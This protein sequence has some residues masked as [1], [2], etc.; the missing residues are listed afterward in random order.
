MNIA[1]TVVAAMLQGVGLVLQQ[2][3]AEQA[4]KS[5]FLRLR[6]IGSLIRRPSWL[7]GITTMT[8][9]NVL[10]GWEIGH[11]PLALTEPLLTSSLLFALALAVPL[12][13]QRL[14]A[15]EIVGAVIL[16]GG[17]A[18]LS[19]A[20]EVAA[21]SASFGSFEAW[22][23]AAGIAVVAYLFVHAG[24]RRCGATRAMFTGIGAGLVFGIGDALT[25]QTVQIMD[26]H[27]FLTVLTSW[28]AYCLA[29]TT[30]VGLWLMENA[31]NAA[32]LHTSLPAMT[33]GE[34]VAGILLGMVVFGDS[35]RIAPGMLAL[36]AV[37]IAALI[38]GVVL[39][40]RAPVFGGLRPAPADRQLRRA[41]VPGTTGA[42][43]ADS[44]DR[45]PD[46]A[47]PVLAVPLPPAADPG[48]ADPV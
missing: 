36:Q 22:P 33:A 39:V 6:L 10:A 28:P 48:F 34:P 9:G 37:G 17:V 42:A 45:G 46:H 20:R 44:G 19:V 11:L 27:P 47:E 40:A 38:A 2:R 1:L 29:A 26:T 14:R 24:H 43:A 25:R 4:P 30:L 16:M 31:F 3:A 5:Y 18:A 15:T 8:A 21:P 23:A 41:D 12:S 7:I 32:P 35:I 13:G